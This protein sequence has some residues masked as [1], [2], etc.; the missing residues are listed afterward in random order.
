MKKT[1]L[2]LSLIPLFLLTLARIQF[3]NLAFGN[4][5]IIEP[6]PVSHIY[7]RSDGAVEP[8]TAPIQR[9]GDVYTLT[10]SIFNFTIEVQRDNVV[11]DGRGFILQGADASAHVGI[12][13]SNCNRVTV[14]DVDIEKFSTGITLK[15]SSSN[16][17]IGNKIRCAYGVVISSSS[18]NN[19]I[20]GNNMTGDV[21]GVKI[22]D[23]SNNTVTGNSIADF[24]AGIY[25][26]GGEYNIISG[27]RFYGRGHSTVYGIGGPNNWNIISENT[28]VG[29]RDDIL[30]TGSN[31]T[32]VESKFLP[33]FIASLLE[34]S[35]P[36]IAFII[37]PENKTYTANNV[38]LKFNINEPASW[39]GYSL[40]WQAYT[41]AFENATLSGLSCG[42]HTLTICAMDSSG[43]IGDSETV[44]FSVAEPFSNTWVDTWVVAAALSVA[45]SGV[46]LLIFMKQNRKG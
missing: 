2:A 38:T 18:S 24:W 16:L 8:S 12:N 10:G 35:T 39:M 20:A 1:A 30:I 40:D 5:A 41:T 23:S 44:Q 9:I 26:Q 31:N 6:P 34:E 15:R 28:I 14:K 17:I 11:I 45:A 46:A 42:P 21:Y 25:L 32:V 19:Y 29:S 4:W 43:N 3:A 13:A 22:T 7:I 36:P 27:N 33:P 37:S